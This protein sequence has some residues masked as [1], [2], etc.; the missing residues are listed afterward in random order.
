M[1]R[2][3]S[4]REGRFGHNGG[5]ATGPFGEDLHQPQVESEVPDEAHG[6]AG[7]SGLVDFVLLH[8]GIGG[9]DGGFGGE[10]LELLAQVREVGKAALVELF[11][12]F[13]F[14]FEADD[15]L[16][17]GLDFIFVHVFWCFGE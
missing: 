7:V 6:G 16:A 2:L 5:V 14:L 11:G 3:G 9:S 15:A 13:D 4:I 1:R 8:G 17:Q 12:A 10:F